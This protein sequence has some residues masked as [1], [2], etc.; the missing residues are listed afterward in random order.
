M[1]G[2]Q[3]HEGALT[4]D[5]IARQVSAEGV[6]TI[7]LVTDEHL[8]SIDQDIGGIASL[9]E[10]CGFNDSGAGVVATQYQ[11]RVHLLRS[12]FFD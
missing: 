5:M 4:V 11:N 2:G 8:G 7:R 3:P 6:E 10:L 12:I 1:T 9:R